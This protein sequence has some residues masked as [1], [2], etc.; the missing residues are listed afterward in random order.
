MNPTGTDPQTQWAEQMRGGLFLSVIMPAYNEAENLSRLILEVKEIVGQSVHIG[1]YEILIVDDHSND[2]TFRL[3]K[4]LNDSRVHCLRLSRRSGSHTALRAGIAH[5]RGDAALCIS[6]DGQDDP[7]ILNSMIEKLKNGSQVVWGVRKKREEPL[8]MR[9]FTLVAYRLIKWLVKPEILVSNLSNADFYLLSRRVIEAIARC[10]ERN[11]SLFG[12]ILWLGFKQDFAEYKRR[13]RLSGKSKW[14]FSSSFRLLTDW[15]IAFSGVPLKLITFLGL[16]TAGLGFLYALFVIIYKLMGYAKP[17]WA[18]T[19]VL[20]L[21]LG[22]TQMMMLGVLG[23][24]L[25]RTLDETK[26][27]PLFFIEDR[28]AGIGQ[29]AEARARTEEVAG[30]NPV[31]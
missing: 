17:G 23:E 26:N 6:A 19:V 27:R 31:T 13:P 29:S 25:W 2:H 16:L 30:K 20:I 28:T 4:S 9:F 18:E 5:A 8:L 15:I 14:H 24:Y 7:H 10:P 1:D 11:T 3:I 21:V 12:L 22:G